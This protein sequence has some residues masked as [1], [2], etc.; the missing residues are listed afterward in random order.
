MRKLL[1]IIL[2]MFCCGAM[3]S[4]QTAEE[5]VAKNTDAKGGIDKIKAIKSYRQ[6]G[7]LQQGS[8]VA[9]VGQE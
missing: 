3:L 6:V 9:E 5:L 4:A 8:F 1:S 2:G 7:K